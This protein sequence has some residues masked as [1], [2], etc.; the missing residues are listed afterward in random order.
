MKI[1]IRIKKHYGNLV[2]LHRIGIRKMTTMKGDA[3]FLHSANTNPNVTLSGSSCESHQTYQTRTKPSRKQ[4]LVVDPALRTVT[5][6]SGRDTAQPKVTHQTRTFLAEYPYSP[7]LLG[8]LEISLFV[9][10]CG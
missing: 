9:A 8:Q 1:K 5:T 2:K 4:N 6:T 10:Y 7:K 3:A